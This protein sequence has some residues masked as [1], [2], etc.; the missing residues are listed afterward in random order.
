M[1]LLA[2]QSS[3]GSFLS[4]GV[5]NQGPVVQMVDNTVHCPDKSLISGSVFTKQTSL[6]KQWTTTIHPGIFL[7][8]ALSADSV[9]PRMNTVVS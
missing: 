4:L 2:F 5:S 1:K 8:R 7:G 3:P 9:S 6:F